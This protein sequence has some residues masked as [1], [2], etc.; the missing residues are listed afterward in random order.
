MT[1]S[2]QIAAL[3]FRLLCSNGVI[4]DSS[5][6]LGNIIEVLDILRGE[7]LRILLA[8][9]YSFECFVSHLNECGIFMSLEMVD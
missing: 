1:V 9:A 7:F 5:S 4:I 2:Q 8:D 6:V 3:K